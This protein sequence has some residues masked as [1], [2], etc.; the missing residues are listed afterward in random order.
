MKI[1]DLEPCGEDGWSRPLF[2]HK[3]TGNYY[4]SVEFNMTLEDIKAGRATLYDKCPINDPDGEPNCPVK[5][6]DS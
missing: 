3:P 1:T 6:T 4:C 2:R 5:V